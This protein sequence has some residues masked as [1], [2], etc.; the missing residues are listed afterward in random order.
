MNRVGRTVHKARTLARRILSLPT[1]LVDARLA[2]KT[3]RVREGAVPATPEDDYAWIAACSLRATRIFDVG[4][5]V[6]QAA[7]IMLLS[8]SVQEIVMVE[9]NPLALSYAAE[10]LIRN[11]L[12]HRVRLVTA[13]ADRADDEEVTLWTY[14]EGAAGSVYRERA[15]TASQHN[16][17]LK[18]PT[19][20]LD[21]LASKFGVPDL[22]KIDVEGAEVRA[23]EGATNI[24]RLGKTRFLVEVHIIPAIST[25]DHVGLILKW[26]APLGYGAWFLPTHERLPL[27]GIPD[28]RCHLMLQPEGW[29]YPDWLKSLPAL[30]PVDLALAQFAGR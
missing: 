28:K 2:G 17:F 18:A 25:L 22:V 5:N 16:A 3:F 15:H 29:D 24:A 7:L 30:S 14:E 11:R 9:P 23:L 19:I 26:C 27:A 6:G 10:N 13:F 1:P 20:R 12:S 4:S 21:T 8:P